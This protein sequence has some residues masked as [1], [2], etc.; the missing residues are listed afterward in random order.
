MMGWVLGRL[1]C[2]LCRKVMAAAGASSSTDT[3]SKLPTA[4]GRLNLTSELQGW[5]G[6]SVGA[7][8]PP[9]QEKENVRFFLV[10]GEVSKAGM[11]TEH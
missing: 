11:D 9:V 8:L 7:C 6:T 10:L 5:K 2:S 1:L 3:A 4:G